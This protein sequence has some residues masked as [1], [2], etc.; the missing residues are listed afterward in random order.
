[1][2][3]TWGF[4]GVLRVGVEVLSMYWCIQAPGIC[5]VNLVFGSVGLL[6]TPDAGIHG[7]SCC[8]WLGLGVVVVLNVEFGAVDA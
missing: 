7:S 6:R 5:V 1:M 8:C 4:G 2:Q 3:P